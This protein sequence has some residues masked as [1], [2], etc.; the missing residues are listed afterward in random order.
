MEADICVHTGVQIN[1]TLKLCIFK[2][3]EITLSTISHDRGEGIV[4]SNKMMNVNL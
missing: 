3:E 1:P 4:L 2:V